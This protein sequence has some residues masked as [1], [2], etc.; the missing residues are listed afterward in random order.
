MVVPMLRPEVFG[1]LASHAGD[2]LF[3]ACY[4]PEFPK[5]ARRLRD[6]FDGSYE[7]FFD[8]LAEVDHFDYKRFA[9]RSRPTATPPAT[10]PTRPPGKALLPV[11]RRDRAAARRDLGA[12]A[13][14]GSRPDGAGHADALRSMKRIHLDA[15]KLDEYYLD[16]GA[17]PSPRR[18]SAPARRARSSSSTAPTAGS[19]YRYPGA[20]R[21]LVD[22][23]AAPPSRHHASTAGHGP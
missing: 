4:L 18:S 13:R 5:V 17:R 1:A 15:G 21:E 2:A 10:R 8:R 11:R 14:L 7:T 22:R 3:E 12:M 6:D 9:A 16:L 23:A 20:I 19:T